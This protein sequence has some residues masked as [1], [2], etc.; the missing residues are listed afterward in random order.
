M[1]SPRPSWRA[2]SIPVDPLAGLRGLL[3]REGKGMGS[4]HLRGWERKARDN[5]AT[6]KE[7]SCPSSENPLQ[8]AL[9]SYFHILNKSINVGYKESPLV[10]ICV[11]RCAGQKVF[12]LYMQNRSKYNH[13]NRSTRYHSRPIWRARLRR[14]PRLMPYPSSRKV[15]RILYT[16]NAIGDC[17]QPFLQTR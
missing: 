15:S 3:L 12:Q 7:C 10:L 1:F 6:G 4:L 13:D 2:H 5:R 16:C 8:N 11:Y 14:H 9:L 17:L